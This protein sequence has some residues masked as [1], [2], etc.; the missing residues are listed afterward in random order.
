MVT[1]LGRARKLCSHHGCPN[2]QP[3]PTH[4]AEPWA[5]HKG[6]H[7]RMRSGS[8]EQKINRAV[9]LRDGGLCA[10]GAL[11][12]QVD[13]VVPLSQGGGDD[14]DNRRAICGPCHDAKTQQEAQRAR[15]A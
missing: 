4:A 9:M 10:C 7:G 11:A 2:F 13:H 1:Q 5:G 14:M 8:R 15:N 6:R 12:E 3:C